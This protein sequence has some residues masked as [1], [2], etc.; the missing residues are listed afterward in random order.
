M[1]LCVYI[2]FQLYVCVCVGDRERERQR[3]INCM[4]QYYKRVSV[5]VRRCV[6]ERESLSMWKAESCGK[7]ERDK[8]LRARFL[9]IFF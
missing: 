9:N 6:G 4:F 8:Q 5:C 1:I 3:E 2:M 7:R